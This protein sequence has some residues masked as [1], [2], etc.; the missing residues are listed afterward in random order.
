VT[1]YID[2]KGDVYECQATAADVLELCTELSLAELEIATGWACWP[3][4]RLWPAFAGCAFSCD[5]DHRGCNAR[6]GCFCPE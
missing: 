3:T 6:T 4:S 1:T 5:L 2:H